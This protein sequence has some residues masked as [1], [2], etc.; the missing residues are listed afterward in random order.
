MLRRALV[1]AAGLLVGAAGL[2]M[3]G[4]TPAL[5]ATPAWQLLA[6]AKSDACTGIGLAQDSTNNTTDGCGDS[7]TQLNTVI[8][9]GIN[10]F[11][12]I[13]G[14]LAVVMIIVAGVRFI[15][16]NGEASKVAGAKGAI[17]Y[18]IVGLIV[19]VAAQSIVWF[20]LSNAG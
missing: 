5:A 17:I 4:N 14:I 12:V 3:L 13:I 2:L 8:K 7:G 1:G 20:V 6:D 19:V 10:I 11:S 15:T 16:S 18:A 9:T